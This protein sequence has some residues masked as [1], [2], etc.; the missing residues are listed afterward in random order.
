VPLE[1]SPSRRDLL[2]GAAAVALATATRTPAAPDVKPFE[3]G[4]VTLADLE[5]RLRSGS[6]SSRALTEK[7]LARIDEIDRKGPGVNSV[8][9]VNPDALAIAADLDR[10]RKE[11]GPRGP[12]HGIPVLIKD[13]I[14][15]ADKMQTT[16]GSLA[17]VG[18]KPPKDSAVARKLREA[19]SVI[20]GKTNLSEWANLR[21]SASTSGWSARGG[22]TKNPYALDRNASG[23]SSGTGA[24][25][26]AGL[27]AVGVG[28][29]TDGSIV[30]PSSACGLVGLK[31]T[32]GLAGRSGIVPIAH[33]QDT[34]GPMGRTVRDVAVLLGALAGPDPD[35]KATADARDRT[36]ADYTTFLDP[37]G[38]KGARIGVLRK[39]TGFGDRTLAVFEEALGA[40]KREGATLIDAVDPKGFGELD[41]PEMTVLLYEF[42]AG[43]NAYLARLGDKAPVKTLDTVIEFNDRN[44]DKE[45]P[46]FGQDLLV[47]ANAKGPLTDKDYLDARATCLKLARTEG[48]DAVM[49]KDRLDALVAPTG[50]PAWL[51]DLVT[52]D[53]YTGG[54]STPA[55][56]AGYPSVT[57]PMGFVFGLPVGLTFFARAWS[58]GPLLK[59]A[60]AFERATKARK[61]PRFLATAELR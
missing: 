9:E 58:E 30:S 18:A 19:G 20:L 44:K 40:M 36:H 48:I 22:L 12:L 33:S 55:A 52:G 24:A 10:E 59:L 50:G 5:A 35:D 26:A 37:K 56:V 8:I 11:K 28:T 23:S 38:F 53:H 60:Y 13:N 3:F 51:T 61:P 31:P 29:E 27:C 42:K 47:K 54:S 45:M 49:E 2:L 17:L 34:A 7:Y 4:E 46:Y 39:L 41:D 32:V 1:P 6:I 21:S 14:D 16:A 15:T 43:L 57:V 25:V